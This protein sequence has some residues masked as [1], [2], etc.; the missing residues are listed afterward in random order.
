M[1]CKECEEY[2]KEIGEEPDCE[3]CDQCVLENIE[4][5]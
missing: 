5:W 3:D 4:E 1:N 2:Y